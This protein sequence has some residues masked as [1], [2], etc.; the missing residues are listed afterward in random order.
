[1]G[2]IFSTVSRNTRILEQS[3]QLSWQEYQETTLFRSYYS[4]RYHS[5]EEKIMLKR[6]TISD[7]EMI[8]ISHGTCLTG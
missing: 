4:A 3:E 5:L 2:I 6:S 1:M 7:P 8:R